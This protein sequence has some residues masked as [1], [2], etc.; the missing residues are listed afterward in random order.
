MKRNSPKGIGRRG[1][2][3]CFVLERFRGRIHSMEARRRGRSDD[4]H[5]ALRVV[6]ITE[7]VDKVKDQPDHS[8][9]RKQCELT[10][11]QSVARV[12]GRQ[13]SLY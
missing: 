4:V 7:A 1:L 6:P 11:T 8:R 5:I 12:E 3:P 9:M 10:P 2:E 13:L